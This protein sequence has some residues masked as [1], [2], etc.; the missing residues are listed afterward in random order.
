[1]N[2]SLSQFFILCRHHV[3]FAI[4]DHLN[5]SFFAKAVQPDVVREIGRA[6]GLHT[7]AVWT[8]TGRTDSKLVFAR[9]PNH[10]GCR[11]NSVRIALHF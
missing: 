7:L 11:T 1:M 10:V 9:E 5:N 2:L 8:V 6:H 4:I 3:D